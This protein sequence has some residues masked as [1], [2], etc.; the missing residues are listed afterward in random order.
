M[1]VYVMVESD[2]EWLPN[3]EKPQK[4][5]P[6]TCWEQRSAL[7]FFKPVDKAVKFDLLDQCENIFVSSSLRELRRCFPRSVSGSQEASSPEQQLSCVAMVGCSRKMQRCS[8]SERLLVNLRTTI[9]GFHSS[10]PC[11]QQ[12]DDLIVPRSRSARCKRL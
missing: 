6:V 1:Y 12:S 4:K 9:T 11:D 5:P 10:R 7:E 2:D 3:A 8:A